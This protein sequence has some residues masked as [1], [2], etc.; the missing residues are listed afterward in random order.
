MSFL[1]L[2]P[3]SFFWV[4]S[5]HI[6]L[7]Q[8]NK[9]N[10]FKTFF[11]ALWWLLLGINLLCSPAHCSVFKIGLLGPW[12]CDPFFSKAFPHVAARLAVGRI[13]KDPSLDLGHRL[14]YVVLEEECETSRALV[15]FIGFGKLYS[16][17]I[18]PLNPGF[19][20]VATLLGENWNKAIFSWMCVNYKLDST[21]HHPT[22]ARTLPSPTQVLFTIMKYF[23][24]ARVGIIAS[25]EDIWMDTA[26]KLASALRSQGLPVRIVTSIHKGEKGIEDTWNEIKGVGDIRII[27][28][29]MHSVLI[30]GKEQAILLTKALEMGLADGRYVFVPYDTLLYSLPYRN[31]S[32][33]VFDNDSK[34]QEAYDAVLTITLEPGE[35]TFYDAFREAKESDEISRE[36]EATQVSPLFGTIYDAIYFMAMAIDSARRKGAG[37]S[38]ANIAGHTKNFSFPGF[39]H[40]VETDNHG[41]GLS[42]YVILDTD[43][44]GN[45]L[46]PTHL[47]DMSSGSVESLN[48]AIHFPSGVPP[49]PDSS[50]WFDPDI[51]C[52]AGIEPTVMILGVMLLFALVLGAVSLGSLI[53]R[54]ILNSQL[55]RGPNK[56]I[57]TLDDVI[58]INPEIYNKRLTLDSLVDANSIGADSKSLKSVTRSS[59]LKSTAATHETSSVALYEGDWVWLKKFE[60]G[61]VHNLRQ[62]STNVLRKMKDLRH[63]N[64]NLFLGFFSDC[65]IFAIV[66]E[67][68]SRGSLEDLLR[69][70]DM[71]LDWMFKS[72]LVMDLIKGI[73]YLH[74]RDFAHGRLKSRNCVVDGRFVLKITDYGYNE[75]LEAQKCPYIQ[76]SPE[77]LLWT[78]PE[79]LRDPDMHRKGTFK[80][81]IYS[82]AIILQEVVVRGPPY[83]MSELSA[84]EIIKKVKKPPPLCRPNIAPE[85]APLKCIQIMKECWGE[86][87]ER[88]PT[89]EEVFHKFKTINKGKK[90]NIIDSM[91]RM[92]EQYSSNLEDLI[93]ERTEELEIEKQKTE[94][95]LS[96]MLPPSVAEAL[97]TGGTVEP[98]YFDQVTI[99]FSDIV[100]FTTI[101]AL[102]EPIEVVDLLNDLY[103]LFDAVLGNHDVYKVETIGDAYM[104]ASGLP[105]RNGNKHA[106]EIANMSL[107]ILSSVGTFK[108][109][110]MPDIPLRIRIGLHTGPCVAGVVGL[111][112]PRYCLFGDTVNTASRMESTGLPY[113]IHV[114]QSTVDTL[115]SLN[116][117]YEIIPRG[118]TELKGKGVEDTYWLVGKKGF[119]KPLP[120]PPEIK[121]GHKWSDALTRKLKSVLSDTKRTLTKATFKELGSMKEARISIEEDEI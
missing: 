7:Y 34:L 85:L 78:A 48:R 52:T 16:A 88:R 76:P 40:R 101:S 62:S 15:R 41:K 21:I 20:E 74:H 31:N 33:S 47:L 37:V 54:S 71:K 72:S 43:G 100:G 68:C 95:L 97:K 2:C 96:Q 103:T 108:M 102:S 121:P 60:A 75:L 10:V 89:F 65:G 56:I 79:L 70:E 14:D 107:D 113:R 27:L 112:M 99:Y 38:G 73:R 109:R 36:L 5:R 116:E 25:N 46:F 110:H 3:N 61:A 12:N 119:L 13:S 9:G 105:K 58:F 66:T 63:E 57:L 44:H 32:F 55:F 90:T 120:K 83:C 64:V 67:H 94:K 80:G 53:R 86:A 1:L 115:R 104:V 35:S 51:P 69:N 39:S 29:C 23:N 117:G 114:S 45:Q 81:D 50:C 30:G 17:F 4:L 24:W 18:G 42:N 8:F 84:E 87:P 92:L 82:F 11:Q 28:L 22:F 26:N 106:A 19:C 111:T 93:R 98:E 118:K 59:S 91:L 49:K 77:E 6:R